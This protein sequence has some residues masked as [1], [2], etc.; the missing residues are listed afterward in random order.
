MATLQKLKTFIKVKKFIT[1]KNSPKHKATEIDY[2][3][4]PWLSSPTS[5]SP[6]PSQEPVSLFHTRINGADY[7]LPVIT[8]LLHP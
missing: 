5:P 2:L 6:S 8:G 1:L 7:R 4:L 3:S